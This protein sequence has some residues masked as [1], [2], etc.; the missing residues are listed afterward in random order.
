[1][2]DLKV[3]LSA[4]TVLAATSLALS[5]WWHRKRSGNRPYPPGPP[6]YPIIGNVHSLFRG[7]RWKLL[8]QYQQQYGDIVHLHGMGTHIFS[9]NSLEVIEDL[10]G[11]RGHIYSHRPVFTVVGELMGLDQSTPLLHY[12]AQWRAHRKFAHQVLSPTSVKQYHVLQ[13]DLAVLLCSD[14][15]NQPEELFSSSRL[16]ASRVVITVTYGLNVR[17]ADHMY[18][19]HAHE[20]MNLVSRATIPGAYLCDFLPF[21]KYLP[22]WM[23]FQKEAVVG[24][25]MIERL[26]ALPYEHVK[27]DLAA[28]SASPSLTRDLLSTID[29]TPDFE[30]Q[31]KWTAGSM[32][33]AGGEATYATIITFILTMLLNQEKQA[34]AQQEIDKVIGSSRLPKVSDMDDL[35]YVNAVIKE[36]MRWHPLLPLTLARRTAQDDFYNGYFI[37]EG[38]LVIPN[39]WSIAFAENSKYDPNEF[40]PERFLDPTVNTIDP[41][42]WAFGF[43]RRV[44]PGKALAQNS[45]FIAIVTILYTFNIAPVDDEK[46]VP[47]F[48]EHLISYPKPFKCVITPRSDAT[49]NMISQRATECYT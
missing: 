21:M 2:I 49:V 33:G 5:F 29:K 20:T 14:I 45:V 12:G 19:K 24:R 13:E 30:Y 32:Y 9:L 35:P 25:E 27:R 37:P 48:E 23:G 26:V 44:C 42:T 8:T 16:F 7:E 22:S 1:M 46:V 17:T 43:G 40:I 18:I 4:I 36:T 3:T 11:K 6:G 15:L 38:S 10:L 47:E 31:A 28:G 34:L 41:Y 39:P